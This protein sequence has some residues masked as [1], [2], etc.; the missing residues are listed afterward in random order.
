[1]GRLDPNETKR[2]FED[3]LRDQ[4]P[5]KWTGNGEGKCRCPFHED[6]AP[7]FSVNCEKGTWVCHAGCGGGGIKDLAER[8]K[9]SPPWEERKR[10]KPAV[11]KTTEYDYFDAEGVLRYQTVR[12]DLDNGTK[13]IWQ[14]RPDG[15]GGWV[16]NTKGLAPLPYRLPELLEKIK[17][18]KGIFIAEGEKCADALRERGFTAT[19]NHG[20]AGKWRDEHSGYIP[21][22]ATVVILPD[23]DEP[24]MKHS[25]QVAGSLYRHGCRV[26]VA[27]LG[28]E[29]QGV[30]GKDVYDWFT[31]GHTKEELLEIVKGTPQWTP[32]D[33]EE[34]DVPMPD[35]E[36][37]PPRKRSRAAD[38]EID[39]PDIGPKGAV[40]QT[41]AN[42]YALLGH[43]G[44]KL[45]Y[46]VIKK[47]MVF[48]LSDGSQ[49]YS[50]DNK[51]NA[52]FG[53]ILSLECKE[54]MPTQHLD[55]FL[56]EMA[57]SN[58]VN[59]VKDW[60]TSKSW[61]GVDRLLY[62]CD[63]LHEEPSFPNDLKNLFVTKWLLSAAAA[64][65]HDDRQRFMTRGVLTL[66]GDQYI[67]KGR[68]F[69][70][71]APQNW[72]KDGHLLDARN[73]DL[74]R[75][76]ISH[77][78]VELGELET[79]LTSKSLGNLKA[80]LTKETDE[81]RIPFAKSFSEFTRR[82]VFGASVNKPDFLI[83]STGNSRF[84]VI[85][86]VGVD[87]N[88]DIDMQQV[89]AQ[90]YVMYRD[91]AQWW[92]TP[93]ENKM[94]EFSNED[95]QERDEVFD[96]LAGIVDWTKFQMDLEEDR[97]DWMT[98][99]RALI[100]ICKVDRP[101]T[102]QQRSAASILRKLTGMKKGKRRYLSANVYPIP[103]R[104]RND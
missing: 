21:T 28:Y 64:A 13:K 35:E 79:S 97:V 7:S 30:H 2:W 87:F 39:F 53:R 59:P 6:K 41:I 73:K 25:T 82:T 10:G 101:T 62:L 74:V 16:N 85:P 4:G 5:I 98:P 49:P 76:A 83:D 102:V 52:F 33:I 93:D 57:D 95:H 70:S 36:E 88:H 15:K 47:E 1:M 51:N 8:L 61:D 26:K 32:E 48:E 17:S 67:G 9:I 38:S 89:F 81:I 94:L 100:E 54:G 31:E 96:L 34:E 14:R 50:V 86:V 103:R 68:W 90:L 84:W 11:M 60:I 37:Q 44:I 22:G 12:Q 19:T 91:G 71:L 23:A 104:R 80:F 69:L 56:V 63:T 72:V 29:T 24:G 75:E 40:L 45:T 55:R 20:G 92:L 18:G 99:T 78:I 27:S 3:A 43:Y 77:W 42:L 58:R 65:C 66:A 46:D